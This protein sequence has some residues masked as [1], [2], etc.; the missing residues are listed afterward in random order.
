M[1]VEAILPLQHS[2]QLDH[3]AET[4]ECLLVDVSHAVI[5][6][7]RRK[8]KSQQKD[9][10]ISAFSLLQ[11]AQPFSVDDEAVFAVETHQLG[12]H[13]QALRAGVDGVADTKALAAAEEHAIEDVA[14]ASSVL[15]S[16]CDDVELRRGQ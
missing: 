12:P 10:Q 8:E 2:C 6:E 1:R 13:P 7:L 5:D 14:F 11:R 15:P 4:L 9:L 16:D 3:Q